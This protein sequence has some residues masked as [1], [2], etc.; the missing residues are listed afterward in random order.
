MRAARN[1]A[2]RHLGVALAPSRLMMAL[3]L[4]RRG[5]WALEIKRMKLNNG[6]ILL[7]SEQHQLPMVTVVDRV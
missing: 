4:W 2:Q 6:A 5:R 7:V 3:S 1:H